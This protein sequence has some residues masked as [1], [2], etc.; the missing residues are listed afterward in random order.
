MPPR[1]VLLVSTSSAQPPDNYDTFLSRLDAAT[2]SLTTRAA[3]LEKAVAAVGL[4]LAPYESAVRKWERRRRLVGEHLAGHTGSP[5][6]RTALTE[7]H[8]VAAKMES[9]LRGRVQLIRDRLTVMHGRREAIHHSLQELE[10]S[11]AKLNSSRLLS[12]DRD[13]LSSIFSSLA[14]ST[15]AVSALPD[16]GLL[17]D[18][19]EAR[20][21]I[22]LAEALM[23][24]KGN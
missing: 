23:E 22:I 17:S 2:T 6:S 5:Q 7:L 1:A 11:R 3:S 13:K 21:A 24:L 19:R 4:L 9:M 20:E 10:S 16:T 18:L 8:D 15:L 14:G 12:Q